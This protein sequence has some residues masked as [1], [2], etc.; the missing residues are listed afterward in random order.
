MRVDEIIHEIKEDKISGASELMRKAI[1][2][3]L[4]FSDT[5]DADTPEKYYKNLLE[6][7]K[8]LINAQPSMAPIFNAVNNVLLV[9]ENELK[10]KISVEELK[11]STKSISDE[12]LIRSK[13]A[14]KNIK[15]EVANLIQD[16]FRILIHSYSSTVIES[17]IFAG[18]QREFEVFVTESR[19]LF[20]GRRTA[21]ILAENGVKTVLI[22]DMASFHFLDEMNMILTGSDCICHNGVVNK[23]GTKGL[24][25][26][27]S[28]YGIPF[29]V[30]SEKSKFLPSKYMNEPRIE[31]KD[32][33]EII[34]GIESIEI[35][36]IYFDI[37]PYEF[38]KSIITEDGIFKA[39]EMKAMLERLEVCKDLIFK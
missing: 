34:E 26:A 17:L 15:E 23:V 20:E 12:L 5:F 9:V 22:A 39:D 27:T 8:K 6:I 35:R 3:L 37:T 25:M 2:C 30:L 36:N 32:P 1:N 19:P 13:N 28:Y 38:L 29:Y 10:K 21:S 16:K 7:G 24:A 31:N 14:L 33:R 11:I 18:T 4:V